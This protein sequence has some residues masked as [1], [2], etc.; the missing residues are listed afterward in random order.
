MRNLLLPIVLALCLL[1]FLIAVATS[2]PALPERVASHFGI[3]G[4]PNG[5]MSRDGEIDFMPG[6][7]PVH[8]DSSPATP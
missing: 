8:S 4:Q 3:D 7:R 2:Y 6:F 1:V 5:W